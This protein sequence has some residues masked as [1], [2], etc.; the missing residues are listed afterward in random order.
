MYLR[1]KSR[2]LG[3]R[4]KMVFQP[5]PK[6]QLRIRQFGTE[7]ANFRGALACGE[8]VITRGSHP[9]LLGLE[10]KTRKGRLPVLWE[11]KFPTP[12]VPTVEPRSHPRGWRCFC[13]R[14][15]DLAVGGAPRGRRQQ[16]RWVSS[17]ARPASLSLALPRT[18][19][20][21]SLFFRW[22]CF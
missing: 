11:S 5:G 10:N 2:H 13:E 15:Q 14:C 9:V 18:C 17:R 21:F 22:F 16:W 19:F 12:P 6:G 20:I 4:S 3:V 8:Y 7:N 1:E